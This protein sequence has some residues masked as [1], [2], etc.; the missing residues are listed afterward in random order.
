MWQLSKPI[1][2]FV[3]LALLAVSIAIAVLW[4]ALPLAAQFQELNDGIADQ[5]R[6]LAQYTGFAAMA[7]D[8]RATEQRRRDALALGEF[9]AG[10]DE[11]AAQTQLQTTVTALAQAGRIRILSARKLPVR[12]RAPLRFVGLGMTLTADIEHMQRFLHA[13]ESAR[14]YLFVDTASIAPLG[15]ANPGPTVRPLLEV[16]LDVYGAWRREP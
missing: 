12:E 8:L 13:L 9:L 6:Q 14:P 16:R 11:P 2:R 5:R 3:A 1:R 7:Q 15:G 4:I 10:D